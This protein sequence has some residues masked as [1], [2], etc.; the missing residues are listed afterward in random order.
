MGLIGQGLNLGRAHSG[1]LK[2]SNTRSFKRFLVNTATGRYRACSGN[3]SIV[4]L[5]IWLD[6]FRY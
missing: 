3:S 1:V 4:K 6:W 5:I 2:S